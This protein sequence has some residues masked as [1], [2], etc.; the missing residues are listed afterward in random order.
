MGIVPG[1]GGYAFAL[2]VIGFIVLALGN[3]VKGL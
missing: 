2:V 1:F 3:M